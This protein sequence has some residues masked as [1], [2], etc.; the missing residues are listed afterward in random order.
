MHPLTRARTDERGVAMIVVMMTLLILTILSATVVVASTESS[1]TTLQEE[2]RAKAFAAAE[3]GLEAAVYRISAQPY[4]GSGTSSTILNQCFTTEFV[5]QP[6]SGNCESSP[7][8]SLGS[9]GSYIYYVSPEMGEST[10]CGSGG[11]AVAC[12]TGHTTKSCTGYPVESSTAGLDLSQRCVTAIGTYEKT[13]IRVQERIVD[14]AFTFPVSGLLSLSNILFDT[15]KSTE[16]FDG[17]PEKEGTKS[18]KPPACPPVYLSG[19]FEANGSIK[20]EG[21][22]YTASKKE[23]DLINGTIA[24]GPK[25]SVSLKDPTYNCPA[26]SLHYEIFGGTKV[27]CSTPVAQSTNYPWSSVAKLSD[28]TSSAVNA[29]TEGEKINEANKSAKTKPYEATKRALIVGSGN[30]S[31]EKPIVIPTGVYN[32]CYMEVNNGYVEIASGSRV[33]IY[34]DNSTTGDGC[35]ATSPNGQLKWP[36][37]GVLNQNSN[38]QTLIIDVCGYVATETSACGEWTGTGPEKSQ[39]TGLVTLNDDLNQTGGPEGNGMT[40]G[41]IYAPDSFYTTT[42]TGLRWT[43]GLVAGNWESNDNDW[44]QGAPGYSNNPTLGFYPVAS[45]RCSTATGSDPTAGCY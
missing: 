37:A 23:Q 12:W 28:Y 27:A 44:I 1:R 9:R 29:K 32:F 20:I 3:A 10:S 22:T 2:R 39:T 5:T 16:G 25:G 4:N 21:A 19:Q 17:C 42:G 38:P 15:N 43:G 7:E 45:H 36:T 11:S 26:E 24:I 18:K 14:Y 13:S 6:A 33:L 30:S 8:E 35:S 40:F 34:I 31:K 41:E